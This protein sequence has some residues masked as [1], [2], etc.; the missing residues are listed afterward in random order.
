MAIRPLVSTLISLLPLNT[1]IAR[2]EMTGG[3]GEKTHFAPLLPTFRHYMLTKTN[4]KAKKGTRITKNVS[5]TQQLAIKNS[6]QKSLLKNI[7]KINNSLESSVNVL[8]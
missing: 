7:A 2:L 4:V 1:A 5:K 3:L 8:H 6:R